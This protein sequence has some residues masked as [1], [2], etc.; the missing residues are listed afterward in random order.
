[1]KKERLIDNL[2]ASKILSVLPIGGSYLS[3]NT[4]NDTAN[5]TAT[6]T[7]IK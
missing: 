1:M 7:L 3:N 4:A 2:M 5:E 6:T